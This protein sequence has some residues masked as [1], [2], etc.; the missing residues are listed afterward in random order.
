MFVAGHGALVSAGSQFRPGTHS[1]GLSITEN[2]LLGRWPSRRAEM[3]IPS[4][5]NWFETSVLG[6]ST[7][8]YADYLRRRGYCA[9]TVHA[10]VSSVG[11]FAYW[12]T[13]CGIQSSRVDEALVHQFV[14][15][16]LPVCTC[17]RRCQR[18]AVEMRAAL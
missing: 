8:S 3:L 14:T 18:R 12:L 11:H 1:A 10:H 15:E 7:D 17:S 9:G 4:S 5:R 13:K 2:A 16:H 6:Q